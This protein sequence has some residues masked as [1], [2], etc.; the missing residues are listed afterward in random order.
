MKVSNNIGPKIGNS[1]ATKTKGSEG[2]KE[3]RNNKSSVSAQEMGA[4]AKLNLSERAQ[5]MQR[6]KDIASDDSIDE[7]RVAELQKLIDSG[8]YNVDASA[9]ADRLVDEHMMFSEE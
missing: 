3:S 9:I 8:K 5:Q 1:E 4:S 6:A 7:A 2:L